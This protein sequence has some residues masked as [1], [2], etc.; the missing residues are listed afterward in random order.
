MASFDINDLIGSSV[1]SASSFAKDLE[2]KSK[3]IFDDLENRVGN[4]FDEVKDKITNKLKSASDDQ[5][6]GQ[7]NGASTSREGSGDPL[8]EF[9]DFSF[10]KLQYPT[11]IQ[12]LDDPDGVVKHWVTFYISEVQGSKYFTE[13]KGGFVGDATQSAVDAENTLTLY[14]TTSAAGN[15]VLTDLARV[16]DRIATDAS[17]VKNSAK[18]GD[19]K[20]AG[21]AAAETFFGGLGRGGLAAAS[22]LGQGVQNLISKRPKTKMLK[23]TIS[24]Y[25]PDTVMTTQNHNYNDVGLT[26]MMGKFGAITQ[27]GG[28]ILKQITGG[29]D[30]GVPLDKIATNAAFSPGGAELAGRLGESVFDAPGLTGA[31]LRTQGAA[32]NPQVELFFNGT[33]RREFQFDFRFNSRSKSETSQIQ[34]II[35][36]FR[37]HSAPSIPGAAQGSD[38]SS[39]G[40]R[41]FALP[42]QF[43]IKFMFRN[44]GLAEENENIAKI[45]TCVLERVDVNYVGSGKFMTFEDGQPVDI[46]VRLSFREIDV[47]SREDIDLKGL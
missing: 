33:S 39:F 2:S 27:A 6:T 28:G 22:G 7:E 19:F 5:D 13:S 40:A 16:G 38:S 8:L 3:N 43:N 37:M 47:I 29:V 25:M 11:E 30:E 17:D 21:V 9:D 12:S 34:Q 20:E 36:A 4:I 10:Q 24:V 41:Y 42:S 45:G 31:L 35:K 32:L 1:L 15:Q 23:K 18:N 44:N 26:E 46:E 14:G